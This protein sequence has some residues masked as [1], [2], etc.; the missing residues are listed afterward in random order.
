MG[1][2]AVPGGSLARETSEKSGVSCGSKKGSLSIDKH[3]LQVHRY[4]Y[5]QQYE[6]VP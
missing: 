2:M 5:E 6:R 3:L 4:V 1:R